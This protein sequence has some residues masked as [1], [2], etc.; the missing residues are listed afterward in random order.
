MTNGIN[1][2]TTGRRRTRGATRRWLLAGGG[3]MVAAVVGLA[4]FQLEKRPEASPVARGEVLAAESG[5]FA[6]HGRAEGEQ[7]MN[8]R[9]LANGTW[10]AKTIPTVWENGI[11]EA[12]V[13]EDW[14]ANG[15]PAD[16]AE[17][18][19]KLFIQMP[20]YRGFMTAAE[21]DAVSAWILAEAVRLSHAEPDEDEGMELDVAAVAKLAPDHLLV[22]GDRLSRQHGCYACHGELG[23]GGVRN[24]ASFKGY[25]PGFF[26]RDF[27]A[28]TEDGDRA[29]I[30]HWIDH[31]RGQAIEAGVAGR[32]AKKFFEGQ[33]IG[34]PA[35]RDR[36][37]EAEKA[38][39]VEYLLWLNR[40]GPLE[41]KEV[42]RIAK[43][44]TAGISQ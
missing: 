24:P 7:R 30:L 31:G 42:E 41:A 35:Y 37:G 27:L 6:C 25:I 38:V 32:L 26:G 15:V 3:I 19:R 17:E 33:A 11:D 1:D 13:L 20:A 16:E 22:L 5:C 40:R 23:Q 28:L 10:R 18:H 2:T 21:V 44:L 9:Q 14:I 43:V 39:L 29:E 34:M 4:V 8:S 36:L 12:A